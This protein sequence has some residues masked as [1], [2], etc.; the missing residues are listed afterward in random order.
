MVTKLTCAGHRETNV[1][2]MPCSDTS[3]TPPTS[4]GLLLEMLNSESLDN[5][6]S[7]LTTGDSDNIELL[8]LAEYLVDVDGLL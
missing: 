7:S 6:G 2:G 5:S 1:G 3:N 8:V 4:M